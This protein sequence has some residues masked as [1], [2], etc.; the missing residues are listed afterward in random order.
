[1]KILGIVVLTAGILALAY[2][3]FTYSRP[4]TKEIG[5]FDIHY[6]TNETVD[7][8]MWGGVILVVAGGVMLAVG[9]RKA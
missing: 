4:H 5:P 7:I 1:M 2:K 6:N 9:M 8:P 3:G